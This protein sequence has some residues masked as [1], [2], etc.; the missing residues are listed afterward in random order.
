M[1]NQMK[2]LTLRGLLLG[3]LITLVFMAANVYLGLKVGL[4]VA[5]SIPAAVIS[6]SVLRR[7]KDSNI[8]EN[9][10]VQTQASAAGTLSSIIFV[11]PALLLV[12]YWND[13]NYWQT[14][15]I[16]SSGGIL[17]VLFTI[18]LR[19]VLVVQSELPYPEGIAA[20][21]ML[22]AGE[23]GEEGKNVRY[24]TIAGI[25]AAMVSF[26]TG[27]LK[28]LNDSASHWFR[29]ENSI[30][31]L[32][33]GFSLALVGAGYLI[34]IGV[35]TV[36]V[37]GTLIN[38][39][40]IVPILT[41]FNPMDV[42]QYSTIEAYATEIW[43]TRVRMMG[44]GAIG[45]G[46]VW[47]LCVLLVPM[48]KS[49]KVSFNSPS[50]HIQTKGDT[51]RDIAPIYIL[52][53][54]ILLTSVLLL[55]FYHIIAPLNLSF[56][57]TI[58]LILI[59]VLLSVIIGFLVSAT[60]G[61]MAGILG[62]SSSPISSIAILTVLIISLTLLVTTKLSI[63]LSDPNLKS[64]FIAL[65]L[66]SASVVVS[67][68][69]IAN[70]NL[71]D[72]KTGYLVGATPAKQQ[73]VLIIGCIAGALVLAPVL[74]MLF[75]AYGFHGLMPREGM[76]PNAALN[77]P[78]ATLMAILAQGVF[79]HNMNWK[80]LNIGIVIGLGVILFDKLLRT[81]SHG[82]YS[83][84]PLAFG[85]GIYLPPSVNIPI[86]LG[87]FLAWLV[88]RKITDEKQY[89]IANKK[90]TLFASGLI[91][92]ESLMGILLALAILISVYNGG[93][94]TPFALNW[95]SGNMSSI[96]TFIVFFSVLIHFYRKITKD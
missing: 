19:K 72:L 23:G 24:I 55:G 96:L 45:I 33:F 46:A 92:G 47:T 34:G 67:V 9:N 36:M 41:Y 77:A 27:G 74:N 93:S 91:V 14:F 59:V 7:F 22:K 38:W 15:L 2:E 86:F 28:L 81:I 80:D 49:I 71:Q 88:R 50:S 42:S 66:L 25:L 48:L 13:F 16:C 21:E 79:S 90:G 54:F 85:M 94:A 87:A 10:L 26:V 20:A 8:L 82:K 17:G 51:D 58:S 73:W 35:A 84:P 76:D 37:L 40:V 64:F 12:G 57:W 11:L 89:E 78:Q 3:F 43:S 30:F 39:N 83:F 1:H 6:M 56:F 75:L 52:L 29:I 62:T 63:E 44:V 32:P 53:L 4:T 60:C 61:Y 95:W 18:P 70:D 69:G 65:S 31:Q 5:S 68:A